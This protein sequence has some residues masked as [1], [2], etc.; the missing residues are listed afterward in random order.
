MAKVGLI[1]QLRASG[2]Q[3]IFLLYTDGVRNMCLLIQF[4]CLLTHIHTGARAVGL[5]LVEKDDKHVRTRP[6]CRSVWCKK[7]KKKKRRPEQIQQH[8]QDKKRSL[9]G[10][11]IKWRNGDKKNPNMFMKWSRYLVK[12]INTLLLQ[13]HTPGPTLPSDMSNSN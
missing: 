3:N 5:V 9:K 6:W 2:T 12:G 4:N 1:T 10:D 11:R 7:T 8:Q 13:N